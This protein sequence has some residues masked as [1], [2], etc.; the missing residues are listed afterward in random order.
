MLL[1]GRSLGVLP[2]ILLIVCTEC[3]EELVDMNKLRE[4]SEHPEKFEEEDDQ[5][6]FLN[7]NEESPLADIKI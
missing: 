4:K 5:N 2:Y 3:I 6:E 7:S 1:T